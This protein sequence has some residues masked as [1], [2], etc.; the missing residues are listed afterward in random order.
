MTFTRD[1]V[2]QA[3]R[4]LYNGNDESD[5]YL[6]SDAPEQLLEEEST[7]EVGCWVKNCNVWISTE[8]IEEQLKQLEAD[9]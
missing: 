5:I 2:F 1:Q 7:I 8:Q 6:P 4:R 3:F 9:Q